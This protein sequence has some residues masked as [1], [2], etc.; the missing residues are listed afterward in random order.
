MGRIFLIALLLTLSGCSSSSDARAQ[1]R[2]GGSSSEP[3]HPDRWADPPVG[4]ELELSAA[5]WR[6]R[7]S[8]K[9]FRVLREQ[10][11]EGA[12]TGRWH[13]HHGEGVY[14][15]AGCGAPLF[16]SEH[17]FDS[18]TGWPSYYRPI[19]DGRVETETDRSL[20]MARTEV[21]CA[22][23]GGH[24]G[25]VFEDGPEPTGLRYCINSVSLDFDAAE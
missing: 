25:H 6:E 20:G 8:E 10:G 9:E 22:R 17:K 5:E 4:Q 3:E 21:H 16:S 18:G 19:A 14:R 15:C 12:F 7:L 2:S 11:T 1:G 23:C 13:D 24:L